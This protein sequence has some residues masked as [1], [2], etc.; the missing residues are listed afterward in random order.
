MSYNYLPL[1]KSV[2]TF[3]QVKHFLKYKPGETF[4]QL[5]AIG[6]AREYSVCPKTTSGFPTGMAIPYPWFDLEKKKESNLWIHPAQVMDRALQRY[7]KLTP[8]EAEREILRMIEAVKA[9]NGNFILILHNETFSENGDWLGWKP[10]CHRVI[11]KL[12]SID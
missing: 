6:I 3:Q 8:E 2:L 5:A 7:E 11:E 9:V 12:T 10:V 4:R 1:D